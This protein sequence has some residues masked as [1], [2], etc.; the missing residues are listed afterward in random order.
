M[1]EVQQVSR[2][3]RA[4]FANLC[5]VYDDER[6]VRVQERPVPAW[7][8]VAFPGGHVEPWESFTAS[9]IRELYDETGLQITNPV[10]CGV[11]Q[12]PISDDTRYVIFLY[13]TNKF[14]GTLRSS[15]EGDVF[16]VRR[17]ELT[18]LKLA[19]DIAEMMPIFESDTYSE[20]F[21]YKDHGEW[22]TK[23]L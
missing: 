7:P 18:K 4:I 8:G 12:C 1:N 22:K 14:S 13:K 15:D 23:V 20:Y 21:Y 19:K 10:L 3:E 6:R 17:D 2:S 16:W 5:M 11:E 9:V